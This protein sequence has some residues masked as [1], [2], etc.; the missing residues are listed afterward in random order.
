M[1][2][3]RCLADVARLELDKL[4]QDVKAAINDLEHQR[5]SVIQAIEAAQSVNDHLGE[6]TDD[7]DWLVIELL[8]T[9]YCLNDI[10]DNVMCEVEQIELNRPL[11]G[12]AQRVPWPI[13][14][15]PVP[16]ETCPSK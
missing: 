6:Y 7:T 10:L 13:R 8:N 15:D 1:D 5:E 4:M 3:R 14:R 9:T 11:P 12:I 2:R 16:A